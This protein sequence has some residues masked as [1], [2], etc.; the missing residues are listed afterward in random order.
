MRIR[1]DHEPLAQ[2]IATLTDTAQQIRDT[3]DA[4]DAEVSALTDHW[5]GHAQHAYTRAQQEWTACAD[6]MQTALTCAATAAA[7][8][9]ARTREAEAHVAGLWS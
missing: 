3:L 6:G 9:Q 1:V 7:R 4:L 2:S 8:A 5:T